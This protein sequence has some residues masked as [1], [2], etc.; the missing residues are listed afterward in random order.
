MP[1]NSQTEVSAR[2]A[3]SPSEK[4]APVSLLSRSANHHKIKADAFLAAIVESSDDA[5]ISKNLDGI[6]TSWNRAA[7][8]IFGYSAEEAIGQP[9][10]ILIPPELVG[11]E[12]GILGRLKRGERIDHYETVRRKKDGSLFDVSLTISPIRN[13]AGRILGAS[14]IARDITERKRVEEELHNSAFILNHSGWAVA[15]INAGT[16]GIEFC[17]AAFAQ[18]HGRTVEKMMGMPFVETFAPEWLPHWPETLEA[19]RR[20]GNYI[21]ESLHVR[22]D[23]STFP[24]RTHA[25]TFDNGSGRPVLRASVFEDITARKQSEDALRKSEALKTGILNS[26]LDAIITI[27]Q[28][29]EVLEFNPAAEQIFGYSRQD[30]IGQRVG[31]LIVPPSLRDAH[32]HG[33]GRYLET[34]ESH[35]LGRRIEI[36]AMRSDGSEFP[37]ELAIFRVPLEGPPLFTA[38]V[39]DITERRRIETALREGEERYRTLFN[40][41]DEGFCIVEVIFDRDN[42]PVDY[43]FLEVNP[44]FEKQTGLAGAKGK[45]MR[46]LA[47]RHEDYWFEIYGGIALTGEPARFQNH[48][49][50]LRRWYDV[51]A[52]RFGDPANRQVAILFND[53]T[54]RKQTEESLAKAKE[55]LE[56]HARNLQ[57]MVTERTAHLQQTIA[58]LEGVSY[59]LSH[60]MRAPLRTIQSFSQ[61][62]LAEAGEKLELAEKDLL[63]RSISAAS[64]LD[65]LIQDVLIYSRVSRETIEF[66]TLDGEQL[67]RQIIHERPELQS[68]EAEIEIQSPIEPV[69]GHEAYLTQCITNLLDN[70]VKFVL[71][72]RPPRV[73]IWS[74]IIDGQVRLWF[75]DNGIGIAKEAQERVFG[76]FQRIH[77]EKTYPGTGIGLA[78]VR[79]AVERMGGRAGVESEP[80]RGSRFWLQLPRASHDE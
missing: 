32:N 41:I 61:I 71:P 17:N 43:R 73:R 29:T 34:G 30:A 62:V 5:I 54:G 67:L 40:S 55:E 9:I 16:D 4:G 53:I 42:Q 46:E 24:V 51:Y 78:I 72:D 31:D 14:K 36:V 23:G 25:T 26:G 44:S 52:F 37:C 19:V 75:E 28:A 58:E 12:A 15:T 10:Y 2:R 63:Q 27:D 59:S 1:G 74:E 21:Y 20:G 60:D 47:P 68:P 8:R 6:I 80:G 50:Q 49:E 57:R 56:H 70:A 33:V 65:R 79:K 39:R 66:G 69:R 35:I 7:E 76:I 3:S 13:K 48:A 38:F 64:R 77:G 22:A 45:K 18:M 11:T